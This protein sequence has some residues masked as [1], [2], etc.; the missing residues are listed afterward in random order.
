MLKYLIYLVGALLIAQPSLSQESEVSFVIRNFGINVDG[1]FNSFE[2]NLDVD[3]TGAVNKIKGTVFVHS[4]ETGIERRDEHLLK[5]DYFDVI[6][7]PEIILISDSLTPLNSTD[8]QIEARLSIKGV[9][10]TIS[11][12][13]SLIE[14]HKRTLFQSEFEINRR[15]FDV[16]GGG[17]L[18]E[19][20]KVNVNYYV[21]E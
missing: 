18:G 10:K 7:H 4:V 17:F 13:G 15:D 2:I 14:E 6:N 19:Q 3:A 20:V 1:H 11:F 5:E 9:T 12:V 21:K 8:Y 16:G